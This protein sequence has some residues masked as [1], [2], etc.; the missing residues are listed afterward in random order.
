ME[1]RTLNPTS[2]AHYTNTGLNFSTMRKPTIPQRIEIVKEEL[3]IT[4]DVEFGKLCGMSKSVV[5][6]LKAGKMKSF[7]ARFAYKLED[8][9]GFLAR[10][11]QLGE[12]PAMHKDA[13]KATASIA[14]HQESRNAYLNPSSK[15]DERR[16]TERRSQSHLDK[17][18]P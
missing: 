7:A 9:S 4:E 13:V 11:L 10:W 17:A 15:P 16:K 12:G 2:Q 6:Q 1:Y 14:I 8:N 3:G 18:Q 5:N